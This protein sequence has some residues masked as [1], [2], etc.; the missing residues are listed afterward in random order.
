[1]GTRDETVEMYAVTGNLT[2]VMLT[3][4]RSPPTG[5]VVVMVMGITGVGKSTFISKLTGEDV[6]I[7]HDLA[8]C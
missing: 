2:A 5:A 6:G 3:E 4:Y 7:G 8:S 1:M